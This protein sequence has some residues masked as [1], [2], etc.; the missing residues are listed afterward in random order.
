MIKGLLSLL[1]NLLAILLVLHAIGSWIP[2]VRESEV[3]LFL[4]RLVS[5]LLE[6]IRRIVPPTAGLDFSPVILL[7]I[8]YFL[9]N[10]LKL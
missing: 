3:Y 7:L 4:D 6:P 9:K 10:L 8:I 5:P 2:R 1:L